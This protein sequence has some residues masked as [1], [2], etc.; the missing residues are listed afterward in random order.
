VIIGFLRILSLEVPTERVGMN[1]MR[2]ERNIEMMN[3]NEGKMT[4]IS[5]WVLIYYYSDGSG[6]P[7]VYPVI[8]NEDGKN[9]LMEVLE[10]LGTLVKYEFVEVYF[11]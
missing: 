2:M 10:E 7:K 8:Y 9:K 3:E 5:H 11:H 1:A 4:R 6:T